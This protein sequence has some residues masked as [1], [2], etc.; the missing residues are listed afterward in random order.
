MAIRMDTI[1]MDITIILIKIQIQIQDLTHPIQHGLQRQ[2]I[3][4]HGL[5]P[6][7]IAPHGQR[8][9]QA[10]IAVAVAAAVLIL[11]IGRARRLAKNAV[12]LHAQVVHLPHHGVQDQARVGILHGLHLL[13]LQVLLPQDAAKSVV[14]DQE[15]ITEAPMEVLMAMVEVNVVKAII[16]DMDHDQMIMMVIPAMA[17]VMAVMTV[18][19][20]D[21]IVVTQ[22]WTP[23]LVLPALKVLIVLALLALTLELKVLEKIVAPKT[24]EQVEL[25]VKN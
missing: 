6:Q 11:L 21:R 25:E 13:L 22:A 16:P 24:K 19:M 4:L 18:A 15:D 7:T 1:I 8:V 9:T 14:R 23:A 2:T 10:R 20:M 3:A 17:V 5:Q 12:H